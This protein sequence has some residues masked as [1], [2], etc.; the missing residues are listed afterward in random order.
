MAKGS[1]RVH[2]HSWVL[3]HGGGLKLEDVQWRGTSPYLNLQAQ[4]YFG[5]RGSRSASAAYSGAFY[6]QIEKCGTLWSDG[7]VELFSQLRSQGLL[8]RELDGRREGELR[9]READVPQVTRAESNIRQLEYVECAQREMDAAAEREANEAQILKAE[10]ITIPEVEAWKEQCQVRFAYSLSPPPRTAGSSLPPIPG[11]QPPSSPPPT[12]AGSSLPPIP[13]QQ[14]PSRRQSNVYYCDCSEGLPDLRKFNR[15]LHKV[16]VLD[17][18]SPKQ[19]I[20]LDLL[21]CSNDDALMEANPTMQHPY[22]VNTD[23][24]MIVIATNTWQAGIGKMLGLDYEWLEANS[25][26]VSVQQPLWKQA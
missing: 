20:V 25:V 8:D 4:E 24:T 13:G 2:V 6:F 26:V 17:E 18:M 21:Q 14:P 15:R 19:A 1:F 11:Q 16:I 3:K 22:I 10:F 23:R 12:T 5:G 9:R 7:S